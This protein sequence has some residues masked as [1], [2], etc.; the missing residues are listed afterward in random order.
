MTRLHP[1]SHA[2]LLLPTATANATH[3]P[4]L[5]GSDTEGEHEEGGHHDL[6]G[7]EGTFGA[8]L[9]LGIGLLLVVA[10]STFFVLRCLKRR[11][12]QQALL[13]RMASPSPK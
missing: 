6:L 7:E 11:R 5:R 8:A 10:L 9:G 3:T 4:S 2:R 1:H 13:A 12:Q